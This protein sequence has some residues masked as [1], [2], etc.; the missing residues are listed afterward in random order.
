MKTFSKILFGIICLVTL[1]WCKIKENPEDPF[2]SYC[3]SAITYMKDKRDQDMKHLIEITKNPIEIYLTAKIIPGNI[4]I[5]HKLDNL[6][7]S[8]LVEKGYGSNVDIC[9]LRQFNKLSFDELFIL[10]SAVTHDSGGTGP[11]YNIYDKNKTPI[12]YEDIYLRMQSLVDKNSG[13]DQCLIL[14]MFASNMT[15][16]VYYKNVVKEKFEQE[17]ISEFLSLF[18]N[19]LN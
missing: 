3:K 5:Q 10:S 2:K 11:N 9:L 6:Y 7:Q 4:E 16:D 8:V 1:L 15:K 18:Q 17:E 12:R 14:S 19:Y 13:I